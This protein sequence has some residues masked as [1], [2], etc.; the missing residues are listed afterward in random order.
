M[1]VTA[2]ED[3][4]EYIGGSFRGLVHPEELEQVEKSIHSQISMSSKGLDYVEYRVIRKDGVI[5]WNRDYGR[6]VH[7][8]IYGDMF[9]V[10][11]EDATERH[12]RE[13]SDAR[14]VQMA[15][16]R[17]DVLRWLEHETTTLR[18]V[19]EVFSSSM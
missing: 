9:Y 3:F 5:R 19:N 10:F 7:T 2:F 12:L 8:S 11:A 18:M 4:K 13:I 14:A 15:R 17:L 6:F 16:E 1:V